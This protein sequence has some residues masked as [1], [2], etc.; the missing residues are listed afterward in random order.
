MLE[1]TGEL[2]HT[3][4]MESANVVLP[5]TSGRKGLFIRRRVI[6]LHL[7]IVSAALIAVAL[8]VHYF[9]VKCHHYDNETSVVLEPSTE[10]PPSLK[11]NPVVVVD[12]RLPKN[13][14]PLHYD[15]RLL[16]WMDE[17]NFTINGFIHILIECVENTNKIVLHSTDIEIDRVSVKI[18]NN[19]EIIEIDE[20]EEN[21]ER[22][23]FII[24]LKSIHL[25]EEGNRY[26]ISMNFTSILNEHQHGFYRASYTEYGQKKYIAMTQME[27]VD[28]RRVFPCFDEPSFKAEFSITL[29]RKRDMISLSNMPKIKTTPIEGV[30]DYE[31]DYFERS[32]PMS[33]YLVAMI[34]ADYS[35]VESNA[36]HNNITFRVWARH[37]AINQTKYG[38]EMGPKMLQFFQEY[39]GIDYPLP[40]QDMIALPSFHGAMENW[41]LI[42][43]GEQQL[44]YDPDMSSDSH[45]EIIAQVIAHEQAH[46]WFGN[47]VTM[48]WWNDLWLNEGFASYMSYIGANHFEPNYR[49]CQQ[50]VINEIQSVMGV[51]GLIT[52]HPINQPVHHPDEINKI[53]DR[54][55]YNKGASIVRML[56]EFLGHGTFQ[57]GLSYYLKS[58]MYGNAVQDD[59]WAALTYQAEL[60]SVQLPTDI[61]TIMDSWTLKMGY[62]VVNVIRNYTSSVITA[63]QERFLMNS[64][65]EL[66]STYRWWI[67]LSYS[68]KA[69]PD[70]V[71]C[72]WIP[73][74]SDQVNI[75]LEATK[76]QWVIFN[77]DQV[78][79]YR[80]NYDQ[81]NWHLI[82]QQLTEDPREISVINR[83]QLI[84]DAF[85]LARTGLLDYSITLNL[86]HYLQ[87][88][89]E[90]IPW[91]SAASGIKFLDSMLCR[92]KIYGIFQDY[93]I[94]MVDGFFHHVGESHDDQRTLRDN[95]IRANT[96]TI[97]WRLACHFQHCGCIQ[98][99]TKLYSNWMDHPDQHIIPTHLKSIVSCTAVEHGGKKEW[100]FAY[101][102]F[103]TSNSA[104]EKDDMLEAMSCTNQAWILKRMI[105]WVIQGPLT[106]MDSIHM[107]IYLVRNPL[108]RYL[109]FDFF[110]IHWDKILNLS[111]RSGMPTFEAL[112]G[113]AIESFNTQAELD[114]MKD[115]LDGKLQGHTGPILRTFDQLIERT[116]ANIFWM[117]RYKENIVLWLSQTAEDLSNFIPKSSRLP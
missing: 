16:P 56:A 11:A 98:R 45:R 100:E 42:T 76:I 99:A 38:L 65:Q 7:L 105:D 2:D 32:V 34:I 66:N 104:T 110:K 116:E 49:L 83:A 46:Q 93:V 28:A 84:D 68:S 18:V 92:T 12:V 20:F 1:S 9:G 26:N 33:S 79:Y 40:K 107:L 62:P 43:Y 69:H 67:P 57:R 44:L 102:K 77:I 113:I 103:N 88:E 54:I 19:A 61:K 6:V 115:F 21:I 101:S 108:G 4:V 25:L 3:A 112:F 87:R 35:Y 37:S 59:L 96:Q 5:G 14:R 52:S 114:Q 55:S 8:A 17:S 75:S 31:W 50:F 111:L 39:F 90:Y 97:A 73:E 23:F 29:G 78:G 71:Q 63:Q 85:N 41:G 72:G 53:F 22:Q 60:D 80:V 47:L 48:Q 51:D 94:R 58:R 109:A 95:P 36:S 70:I 10:N 81:H 86:T 82:I 64:R 117:D 24:H 74:H 106:K 13:L 91:R 89:V 15:I 27:P 30:S